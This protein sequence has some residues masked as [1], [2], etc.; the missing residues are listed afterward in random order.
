V[1]CA[2]GVVVC[3][4]GEAV[5]APGVA[6]CGVGEAVCAPGV[7]VCGVGLAVCPVDVVPVCATDID[8]SAST[9]ENSVVS[10]FFIESLQ[11]R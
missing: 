8:V 6:V 7:A 5:C 11:E 4:V 10:R 1:V 3:G 9:N 2:P